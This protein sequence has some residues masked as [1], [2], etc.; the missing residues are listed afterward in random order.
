ML[1]VCRGLS[2]PYWLHA[3]APTPVP[4][5][6]WATG[7][8]LSQPWHPLGWV[9]LV[10]K[11]LE[12]YLKNTALKAPWANNRPLLRLPPFCLAGVGFPHTLQHPLQQ[13][14]REKSLCVFTLYCVCSTQA[15]GPWEGLGWLQVTWSLPFCFRFGFQLSVMPGTETTWLQLGSLG[16][17]EAGACAV[18]WT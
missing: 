3:S 8:V 12:W 14:Q 10:K 4:R 15:R 9:L 13:S 11:L 18:P 16:R 2:G 5:R 1:S 6:A 17:S 7:L